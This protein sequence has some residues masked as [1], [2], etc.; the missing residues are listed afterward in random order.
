MQWL[1]IAGLMV[2][3]LQETPVQPAVLTFLSKFIIA[4]VLDIMHILN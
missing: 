1:L 4:V 2:K 3:D